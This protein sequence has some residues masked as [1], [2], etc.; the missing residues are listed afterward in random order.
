MDPL[1][2]FGE[3][4][5]GRG[6]ISEVRR[7]RGSLD[8]TRPIYPKAMPVILMTAAEVETRMLFSNACRA[9]DY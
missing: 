3:R 9:S 5:R 2:A 1:K 4:G 6:P 8:E 7:S